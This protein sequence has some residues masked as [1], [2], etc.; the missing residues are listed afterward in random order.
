MMKGSKMSANISPDIHTMLGGRTDSA[1]GTSRLGS[2]PLCCVLLLGPGTRRA[3]PPNTTTTDDLIRYA[4]ALSA[5]SLQIV[6]LLF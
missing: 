5:P 1:H 4:F 6:L 3:L 2:V